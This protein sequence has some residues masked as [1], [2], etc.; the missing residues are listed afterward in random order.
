MAVYDTDR[1]TV[2]PLADAR[3]GTDV[4]G[5]T[6]TVTYATPLW[7]QV[8]LDKDPDELAYRTFGSDELSH[9]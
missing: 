7:A 1:V 2:L 5:L 4:A 6:G 9:A 3:R 8:A